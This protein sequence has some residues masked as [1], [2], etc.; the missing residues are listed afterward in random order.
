MP[1]LVSTIK[2]I[3]ASREYYDF[4]PPSGGYMEPAAELEFFGDLNDWIR[5]GPEHR[6][7]LEYALA[8][9][10]LSL[11]NSTGLLIKDTVTGATREVSLASGTLTTVVPAWVPTTTTTTTTTTSS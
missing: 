2:N 3:S 6:A 7:A 5:Q 4:L 8:Q 9:G 1:A 10:K 11:V